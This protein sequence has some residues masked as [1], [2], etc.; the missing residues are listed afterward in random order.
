MARTGAAGI[1]VVAALLLI[2]PGAQGAVTAK[3]PS[4]S[5]SSL[6]YG[7]YEYRVVG[8]AASERPHTRTEG[9][10]VTECSG[11]DQKVTDF[12]HDYPS[13]RTD[14]TTPTASVLLPEGYRCL[15]TVSWLVGG[16]GAAGGQGE[17]GTSPP[18]IIDTTPQRFK[19]RFSEDTKANA[20][21][22]RDAARRAAAKNYA[23]GQFVPAFNGIAAIE[24]GL[25]AGAARIA[26]D[27]PD[28]K[29][30]E[31]VRLVRVPPVKAPSSEFGSATAAFDAY[32]DAGADVVASGIALVRAIDKAQGATKA[33]KKADRKKFERRQMLAAAGFAKRYAGALDRLRE[34]A[35]AA[36][37]AMRASDAPA[38][39]RSVAPADWDEIREALIFHGPSAGYTA[40]LKRLRVPKDLRRSAALDLAAPTTLLPGTLADEVDNAQTLYATK[41][42]AQAMRRWAKAVKK[43]PT[44]AAPA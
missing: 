26:L 3:K 9:K 36:A 39:S 16:G 27:P 17:T 42:M 13:A 40:E 5:L 43:H 22:I 2:A 14:F 32:L 35:A 15:I 8:T 41:N 6:I 20:R 31:K 19:P 28:P 24:Q 44:A 21:S 34:R 37:A 4:L 12:I 7:S 38:G 11:N 18:A 10:I 29:F 33:R 25:A 1:L 30:R 23:Y